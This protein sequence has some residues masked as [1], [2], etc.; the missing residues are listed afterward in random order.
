MERGREQGSKKKGAL[1]NHDGN[2]MEVTKIKEVQ[3]RSSNAGGKKQDCSRREVL[4]CARKR[5]ER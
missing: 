3:R 2:G 5:K 1:I 4:E